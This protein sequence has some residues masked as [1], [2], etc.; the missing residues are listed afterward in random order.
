MEP[1]FYPEW[2]TNL[3]SEDKGPGTRTAKKFLAAEKL[4]DTQRLSILLILGGTEEA[5]ISNAERV[6]DLL[7]DVLETGPEKVI[8]NGYFHVPSLF[9]IFIFCL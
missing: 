6:R 3:A 1:K 9:W 8:D 5:F 4:S 7:E 2:L